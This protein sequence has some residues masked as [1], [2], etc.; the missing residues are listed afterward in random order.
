MAP[1]LAWAQL[2]RLL[3]AEGAGLPQEEAGRAPVPGLGAAPGWPVK[4][5]PSEWGGGFRRSHPP[6]AGD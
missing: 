2:D 5:K 4:V 6:A 1:G 3:G